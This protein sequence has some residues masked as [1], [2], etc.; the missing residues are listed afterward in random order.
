MDLWLVDEAQGVEEGRPGSGTGSG[1]EGPARIRDRTGQGYCSLLG[2]SSEYGFRQANEGALCS[3][4]L[5]PL[6]A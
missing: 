4:F 3:S 6:L 1:V 2:C 5:L